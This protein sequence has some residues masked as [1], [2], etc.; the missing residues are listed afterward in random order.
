MRPFEL[1]AYFSHWNHAV[2]HD[3]TASDS[4]TIT[5]K[6][7]LALAEPQDRQRFDNLTLGYTNPRGAEWLREAIATAYDTI[8]PADLIC[9]SG[10]QEGIYA[11]M[12][13]LLGP[14]DHAIIV[15]PNY[16][17]AETVPASLCAVSGI[18]LDEAR[19]WTLDIDAVRQAIRP[20]TRLI[21]INFPNNP[22][23][24]ILERDR[25][26]ALVSLCRAQGIW[27]FSDEVYRLI[28][29]AHHAPLPQ[30]AD[31]YERGLSLNAL[32]KAYGLPGLRV[33]W[34][35]CRDRALLQA[36]EQQKH[37]LSI[38]NAAPSEVLA[39]IALRAEHTIV[40]RNRGIA[41][42][43]FSLLRAF[44]AGR[45]DLFAWHEPDGGVVAYPR[46]LGA[47]GVEAFVQRLI[48]T[49]GVLLLP[50]SVY[51]SDLTPSPDA[52]F[53]IGFGRADF[54]QSLAALAAQLPPAYVSVKQGQH[55]Q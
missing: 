23:G 19:G 45:P 26:D 55:T 7:L 36:M 22:T 30:V 43:N 44:L 6:E 9:F 29:R 35:A 32:S 33:G 14:D 11:A 34:I 50:A 25:F 5:L 24:K 8:A 21:S 15:T 13:A 46:Y 51:Q 28:R 42:D 41:A 18:A 2:R 17:S 39:R 40:G 37:Y 53:R 48:H 54:P 10:A 31:V 49:A 1:E 16:Q 52:H 47:E 12:H 3:L 27:L 20:N 38:C 4:Q